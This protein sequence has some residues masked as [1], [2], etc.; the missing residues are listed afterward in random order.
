MEEDED[1]RF[2]VKIN[3]QELLQILEKRFSEKGAVHKHIF[4]KQLCGETITIKEKTFH[5]FYN[6]F[7]YDDKSNTFAEIVT[8]ESNLQ[9]LPISGVVLKDHNSYLKTV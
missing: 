6:S 5:L 2:I 8:K 7:L 9:F 1:I 4:N 3:G